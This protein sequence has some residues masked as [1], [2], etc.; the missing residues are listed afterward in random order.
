MRPSP[1]EERL[2]IRAERVHGSGIRDESPGTGRLFEL[3]AVPVFPSCCAPKTRPL[4]HQ[5]E[6][7]FEGNINVRRGCWKTST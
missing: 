6:M 1:R 3:T 5:N 7:E 2:T 4:N